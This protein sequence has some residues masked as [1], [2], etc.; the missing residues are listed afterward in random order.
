MKVS[1]YMAKLKDIMSYA[2]LILVIVSIREKKIM[3]NV[4]KGVF[5]NRVFEKTHLY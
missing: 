1:R 2:C 3:N 4:A 5:V